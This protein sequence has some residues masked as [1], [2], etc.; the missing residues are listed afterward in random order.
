MWVRPGKLST[1][2]PKQN[3][4]HNP[5]RQKMWVRPGKLSPLVSKQKS[6]RMITVTLCNWGNKIDVV[7]FEQLQ[8]R[9]H[10]AINGKCYKQH[11]IKMNKKLK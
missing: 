7:Y 11:A 5:E 8:L 10:L 4:H 1:P 3:I 2:M 9:E 6:H